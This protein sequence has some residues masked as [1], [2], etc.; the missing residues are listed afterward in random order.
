MLT[1]LD[2]DPERAF[3]FAVVMHLLVFMPP[4]LIALGVMLRFGS[5]ALLH[6]ERPGLADAEVVS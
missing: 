6:K 5:Q 1:A 3:S 4:L 2:A